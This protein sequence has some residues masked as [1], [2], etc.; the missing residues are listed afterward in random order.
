M[1]GGIAKFSN[2]VGLHYSRYNK[3]N[4]NGPFSNYNHL[5]NLSLKDIV[6]NSDAELMDGLRNLYEKTEDGLLR[7]TTKID[8]AKHSKNYQS[9]HQSAIYYQLVDKYDI[10]LGPVSFLKDLTEDK[11]FKVITQ[12]GHRNSWYIS[13]ILMSYAVLIAFNNKHGLNHGLMELLIEY[14]NQIQC[15]KTGLWVSD[16]GPSDL[17]SMA[18]TFHYLPIYKYMDITPDRCTEM[19][20]SI[21]RLSTSQGYF[22]YPSGYACLD[23][24]G[25]SSLKY[26][27]GKVELGEGDKK[28]LAGLARR[29]KTNIISMQNP[30][31]GFPEVGPLNSLAGDMIAIH[32]YS[33]KTK[34]IWTYAWNTKFTLRS[35]FSKNHVFYANSSASCAARAF[36]SN[37]FATWFRYLTVSCC[38]DIIDQ[39]EK[40]GER[41]ARPLEVSLPGLGYL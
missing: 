41:K 36:D 19:Y 30:D 6:S 9:L 35:Y 38:E 22:S 7:E 15:K 21:L 20:K 37:T 12:L 32:K 18:G 1:I 39:T 11:F 2:E 3:D 29:L 14:L 17:N 40:N 5:Y 31:G 4:Y 23:Y 28:T 33:L 13:N 25:I 16:K 10:D 26:L 27:L 8:G 24:D 34:C